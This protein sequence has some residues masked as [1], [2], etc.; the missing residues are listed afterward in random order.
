MRTIPKVLAVLA[1]VLAS[2]S[3]RGASEISLIGSGGLSP[4]A[5]ASTDCGGGGSGY[6]SDGGSYDYD[7]GL[8]G[9]DGG[10]W[11]QPDGG[12]YEP[13]GGYYGLDAGI[14]EDAGSGHHHH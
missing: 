11:G 8:Y 6:N 10:S 7:A 9:N 4:D 2:C 14:S 5:G 3:L 1:L 13:D 12:Y